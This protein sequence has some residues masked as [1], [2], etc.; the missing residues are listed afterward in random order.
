MS[1]K[2]PSCSSTAYTLIDCG[3]KFEKA[4]CDTCSAEW[5]IEEVANTSVKSDG[6]GSQNYYDLPLGAEQLQ[7]LIEHRNMNGNVKDIF[8]SCYRAG[9]KEGTSEEY[10][11]RKRVYYSLRELGRILNRKDYITL[12][13]EIIAHQ[14]KELNK[15]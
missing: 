6:G 7:D 14:A 3:S 12:A 10:D 2:C 8:K 1:H 4:I 5:T 9:L 13:N 11:A 15:D